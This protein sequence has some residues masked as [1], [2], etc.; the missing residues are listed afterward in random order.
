MEK[1]KR[2]GSMKSEVVALA[3]WPPEVLAYAYA[4]Y[5]RS[6][7]SI[8]ESILKITNEKAAGFLDT[9]YFK[10]GHK[11]IA[12]NA[13]IPLAVEN[14]SEI[15]AFE[16]ED[17]QLWDGQERS[18]RYQN[19]S[20]ADAYFVPRAI[21]NTPY[22]REYCVVADFLLS[23][24]DDYS[25]FC[26]EYLAKKYSKPQEM[27]DADYERTLRARAFDVARYWLFNGVLTSVGQITS[28]KTLEDQLC[29]LMASEYSETV[30]V[31]NQMKEACQSKPF[32][33]DG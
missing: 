6:S 3:G 26:F 31:A 24:Y 17:E 16:I 33:P 30:F 18:T 13:H 25:S 12:D 32:C 11:S 21:R 7:L 29:R 22:E 15:V 5:S 19:F 10:Y 9:F 27:K 28:A 4:M 20:K 2:G 1:E 8:R 23:K 14:V